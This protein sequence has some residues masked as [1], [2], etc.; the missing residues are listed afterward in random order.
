MANN[1]TLDR[2][3]DEA[4]ISQINRVFKTYKTGEM[5]NSMANM[6]QDSVLADLLDTP[7]QSSNQP[8]R[9]PQR[10]Q[11]AFNIDIG[12]MMPI[13]RQANV[14]RPATRNNEMDVESAIARASQSQENVENPRRGTNRMSE[15]VYLHEPLAGLLNPMD[16]ERRDQGGPRAFSEIVR[17]NRQERVLQASQD[18]S[19]STLNYNSFLEDY[20]K[21]EYRQGLI[22][23]IFGC[24][25][26]KELFEESSFY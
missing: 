22:S 16:I 20:I 21:P 15:L 10:R 23:S 9:P 13:S 12:F 11:M 17:R 19:F 26:F 4:S 8:V 7:S 2:R 18:Q 5:M 6:L 25:K 14:G 1:L 24:L 3:Y